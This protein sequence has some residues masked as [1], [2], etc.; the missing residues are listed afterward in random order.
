MIINEIR[1]N[2]VSRRIQKVVQQPQQGQWTK[3]DN[4]LTWNEIWHM[5]PLTSDQ[6]SHQIS[7][8]STTLKR[9]S[10]T[11]GK[12]RG[13]HLS[14]MPRACLELMQNLPLTRAIHLKA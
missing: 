9:K 11:V 13:P 10:G 1:S 7:V 6:L 2:E 14:A 4:A 5:V 8:R 12:E 3:W